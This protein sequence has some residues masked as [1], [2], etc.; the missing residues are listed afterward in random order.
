MTHDLPILRLGDI[1]FRITRDARIPKSA[2]APLGPL[3][4]AMPGAKPAHAHVSLAL[5]EALP[6]RAPSAVAS[7][8]HGRVQ[9]HAD[10]DGALHVEDGSACV[11]VDPG[12]RAIHAALTE[13]ALDPRGIFA[14]TTLNIALVLAL[15]WHARFHVHAGLCATRDGQT[16]LLVGPSGAGKSTTTAL[17]GEA[18]LSM[19]SDDACL[20]SEGDRHAIAAPL[21][22][23]F[24]LSAE[25]LPRLPGLSALG[26]DEIAP[27]RLEAR[28][29]PAPSSPRHVDRILL[30]SADRAPRTH[31][32]RVAPAE[33]FSG[34]LESSALLAAEGLPWRQAHFALLGV[35]AAQ[36]STVTL[37]PGPDFF[38]DPHAVWRR[39]DAASGG[40]P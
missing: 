10:D 40:V 9:V 2:F 34:L 12:G 16:L 14:R 21:P 3:A 4:P 5:V 17:L 31:V 20:L 30:I 15:R 32:E 35:L 28:R 26:W 25:A 36:A 39:I 11:R 18:G 24:H 22:R 19:L 6:P 37:V 27:A 38:D 33:G 23:P 13:P 8:F 7:F 1:T 29:A